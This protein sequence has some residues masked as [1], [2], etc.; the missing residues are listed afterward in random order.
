MCSQRRCKPP[1]PA[2][3]STPSCCIGGNWTGLRLNQLVLLALC[4][5]LSVTLYLSHCLSVS[6]SDSVSLCL[7]PSLCLSVSLSLC[8]SVVLCHCRSVSVS[9]CLSVSVSFCLC[10]SVFLYLCLS[11]SPSIMPIQISVLEGYLSENKINI[12]EL[13]AYSERYGT[14]SKGEI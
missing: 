4:L 7:T 11:V 2:T 12:S 13:M 10:V 5:T 14:W 9:L 8:V 3:P 1:G 6:V